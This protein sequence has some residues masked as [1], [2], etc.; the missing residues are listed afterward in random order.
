MLIEPEALQ[1]RLD[2]PDLRIIDAT[3]Y[4][5]AQGRNAR[6]EYALEHIPGALYVDLSTD[7]AEP[8]APIRN[9][10]A[11]PPA[12][13]GTFARAGI[14]T[15]HRVVVYDRRGG[16]SA[17]RIWWA[18]RYAGH[19][20]PALLDGGYA[21]WIAEG[22]PVTSHVPVFP[23]ASFESTPREEILA[24]KE[25]VLRALAE[26]DTVIVDARSLERFRGNGEESTRHRGHIPGSVCVPYGSNL[27][28]ELAFLPTAELREIYE[29]AGV[30]FDRP[31]ITTCGSGV[32]AS[33]NAFA[34]M[35][36]GHRDVRVYDGSWAEWGDLDDVPHER[37]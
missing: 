23:E 11:E 35:L 15:E 12:L 8:G 18:L 21:R 26:Q 1:A 6:E 31:V 33:L 10:I 2:E 24:R 29:K 25:D 14:G 20:G 27:D 9:T 13:A 28:D 17:G 7:L 4:L 34:L 32:T 3:W 16:Y 5:P 36:I 19:P 30:R 37:T 22:R